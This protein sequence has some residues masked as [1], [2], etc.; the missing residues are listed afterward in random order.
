MLYIKPMKLIHSDHVFAVGRFLKWKVT[1]V[2]L[3]QL[4]VYFSTTSPS[5]PPHSFWDIVIMLLIFA[6]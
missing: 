5:N 2:D 1:L 4:F 6:I 3:Q